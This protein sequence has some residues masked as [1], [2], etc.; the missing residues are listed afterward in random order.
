MV[1]NK[2]DEFD[3]KIIEILQ[4]EARIDISKI[5]KL[6]NLSHTP[7]T[8]RIRKLQEAGIITGYV[9]LLDRKKTSMPVLV[10]LMVKLKDPNTRLFADFEEMVTIMPEVQSCYLISGNWNFIMHVTAAT[11]QDYAAWIF[12]KILCYSY[13]A[14]VESA[15][16]M[17]E[18]KRFGPIPIIG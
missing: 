10:I 17:R 8:E 4:K 3:V 11:P 7:V 2:L 9:A 14:D 15:Y 6:V 13:I 16:L 5:A 18:S 1:G 12:E